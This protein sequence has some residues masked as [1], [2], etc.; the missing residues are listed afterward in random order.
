MKRRVGFLITGLLLITVILSFAFANAYASASQATQ[1]DPDALQTTSVKI[2]KGAKGLI[3]RM[4][5]L[6]TGKSSITEFGVAFAFI[7]K[8]QERVFAY[9]LTFDGYINEI[10]YWVYNPQ[11]AIKPGETYLT[12]DV[13]AEFTDVAEVAVAIRYYGK[14][15]GE[16]VNIPESQW[17]GFSSKDG[18]N[19]SVQDRTF[20][21]DPDSATV[22][23]VNKVTLGYH[24]YLLDDYNAEY[25]A[26][27]QGGVWIDEISIGGLADDA[28]FLVGD[29]IISV[30]G[31]KLTE[32]NYAIVYGLEK[33]AAGESVEVE[34]ER[35]GNIETLTLS[36]DP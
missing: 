13:F 26:H 18:V 24:Y 34:Y 16:Y 35:D 17:I 1:S 9:P 7:N 27:S 12:E 5:F 36:L 32:N 23:Q 15:N 8:N 21:G 10:C 14:E 11:E 28:G 31:I 30:D 20:Y 3:L 29:L 4:E 2:A 6:N 19:N 33:I 22:E 25:Y